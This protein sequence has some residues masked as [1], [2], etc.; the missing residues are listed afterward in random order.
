MWDEVSSL[1]IKVKDLSLLP[2]ALQVA[3]GAAKLDA[4]APC[5]K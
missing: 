4:E 2:P 3:Y 5:N 1:E